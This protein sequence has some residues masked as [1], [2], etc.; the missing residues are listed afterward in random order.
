MVKVAHTKDE[1]TPKQSTEKIPRDCNQSWPDRRESGDN[2]DHHCC[3][4]DEEIK[5][6]GEHS[7]PR[8]CEKSASEADTE[9]LYTSLL[10]LNSMMGAKHLWKNLALFS[11]LENPGV[12]FRVYWTPWPVIC[13]SD[14]LGVGFIQSNTVAWSVNICVYVCHSLMGNSHFQMTLGLVSS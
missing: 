10:Q 3:F 4:R 1:E 7:F 9:H 12:Y 8:L 2:E 11:S 14:N 6:K 5:A 13:G